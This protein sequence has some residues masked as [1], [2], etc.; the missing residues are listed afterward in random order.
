MSYFAREFL[1]R[2]QEIATHKWI[3]GTN[4][5]YDKNIAEL[6][7]I[8]DT[9]HKIDKTTFGQYTGIIDSNNNKIFEGDIILVKNHKLLVY[10]DA[11][12]KGWHCTDIQ[13]NNNN[14]SLWYRASLSWISKMSMEIVGNVYD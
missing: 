8:T 1:F 14:K 7:I 10:W 2:G 6:F 4:I 3:V 11:E 12:Y 13:S 5:V 9:C